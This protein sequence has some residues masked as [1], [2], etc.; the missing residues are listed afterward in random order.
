MNIAQ[1]SQL[2]NY[3]RQ[4]GVQNFLKK[5]RLMTVRIKISYHA[6]K[7]RC[8][9]KE[10]ICRQI[11]EVYFERKKLGLIQNEWP[12]ITNQKVLLKLIN[13][14]S[15]N[16]A[17]IVRESPD[18]ELQNLLQRMNSGKQILEK[19]SQDEESN[20]SS[21]SRIIEKK[22]GPPTSMNT[23]IDDANIAL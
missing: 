7:E 4:M 17:E 20:H 6:F 8:S 9:V 3:N 21:G 13:G 11:L 23:P 15:Q 12:S 10:F 16:L 1:K 2:V 22:S 18:E 14:N 5:M 19:D